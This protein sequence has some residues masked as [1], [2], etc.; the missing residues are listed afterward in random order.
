M[1]MENSQKYTQAAQ[2]MIDKLRQTCTN[3]NNSAIMPAHLLLELCQDGTRS[4]ELMEAVVG[5]S[6]LADLRSDLDVALYEPSASEGKDADFFNQTRHYRGKVHEVATRRRGAP[7]PIAA[8]QQGRQGNGTCGTL[9]QC[10][11]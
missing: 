1:N 7:S 5:A 2:T 11:H 6:R 4:A 8:T 9:Y 3:H 10:R